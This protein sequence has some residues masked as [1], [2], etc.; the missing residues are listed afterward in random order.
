M[1]AFGSPSP[2]WANLSDCGIFTCTGLY[3]VLVEMEGTKFS[4]IP[5]VFGVKPNFQ[6]TAHNKES[7][8]VQDVANCE[9]VD[10]WNAWKCDNSN[11]GVLLFESQDGDR[12]DR[13]SQPLYLQDLDDDGNGFNNR[14]NAYMDT[15]WDGAYTCQKREQRFPTFLDISRNYTIEYTG[16]PPQKQKFSLYSDSSHPGTLITIRYPDA[17]AYKIYNEMQELVEPTDW[18]YNTETWAVPSGREC[19]ENRYVGVKNFLEFWIEPGC[20]IFVYPRDAIMLAIRL[21]WTVKE[22]FQSDGIGKF[23]DRMAA[24]LGIHK[25]DLKVVQV[26]EGSVIVEFQVLT[27]EGDENPTATLQAIEQK[28]QDSAPTLGDSLGAPVM[29]V[30]TSSGNIVAMEGYE[31]I[32]ALQNNGNFVDLISQFEQSQAEE[33]EKD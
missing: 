24:V 16:T 9:K 17:G 22:F 21:E 8:S 15:C 18:D 3:N 25:A 33:A 11:L 26:Y 20:T 2:G 19:G 14:L 23:T 29:Q 32:S 28:F 30:V 27:E 13:S 1:F 10:D 5:S 6:V 4:G 7:I 12:M 31:D